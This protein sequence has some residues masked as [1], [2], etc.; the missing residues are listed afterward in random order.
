MLSFIFRRLIIIIPM[1][2]VVVSVT[3]WLIR[4]APGNFYDSDKPLPPA[5]E[6]NIKKKYGLD[7]PVWRQYTRMLGNIT[8]R[9]MEADEATTNGVQFTLGYKF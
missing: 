9:T 8:C 7:Q 5:I 4:L 6:A 3:W 1:A 2:L